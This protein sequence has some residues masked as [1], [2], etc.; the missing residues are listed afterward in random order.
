MALWKNCILKKKIVKCR[1]NHSNNFI[2]LQEFI[3]IV[4]A[5]HSIVWNRQEEH[6][7]I[8]LITHLKIIT[9]VSGL[10][11][12]YHQSVHKEENNKTHVILNL[13]TRHKI[14]KKTCQHFKVFNKLEEKYLT[15]L[16]SSNK[17]KISLIT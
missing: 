6:Y 13:L 11:T 2:I 3:T 5:D 12:K 15:L 10:H 7:Q 14:I 9:K 4:S 1:A 17:L 8:Q 16:L